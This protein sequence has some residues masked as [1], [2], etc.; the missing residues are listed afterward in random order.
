MDSPASHEIEIPADEARDLADTYAGWARDGAVGQLLV[1]FNQRARLREGPSP[2]VLARTIREVQAAC[3]ERLRLHPVLGDEVERFGR[4]CPPWLLV[5][6]LAPLSEPL[7]ARPRYR[8]VVRDGMGLDYLFA[9]V[10]FGVTSGRSLFWNFFDHCSR[11]AGAK[12]DDN[13]IDPHTD[14]CDTVWLAPLHG[15]PEAVTWVAAVADVVA[16]LEERHLQV[17][18]SHRYHVVWSD[19]FSHRLLALAG[20]DATEPFPLLV[21]ENGRPRLHANATLVFELVNRAT[22]GVDDE[23]EAARFALLRQL[24]N[25]QLYRSFCLQRGEMLAIG[26]RDSFHWVGRHGPGRWVLRL[27]VLGNPSPTAAPT[28]ALTQGLAPALPGPSGD[29][30][31]ARDE[32]AI[33][34][35]LTRLTAETRPLLLRDLDLGTLAS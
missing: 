15:L 13:A 21:I 34:R 11:P 8:E 32:A 12:R 19:F 5:R 2:E 35:D 29:Q 3:W 20:R 16:A 24:L 31:G 10:A 1:A 26:N 17:L 7:P 28:P 4:E 30:L 33:R 6:G 23:A 9:A 22:R 18:T 27:E 14:A 25:R